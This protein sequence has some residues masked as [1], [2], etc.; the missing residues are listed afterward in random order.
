[1]INHTNIPFHD[2]RLKRI[3]ALLEDL[4]PHQHTDGMNECAICDQELDEAILIEL[5][6]LIADR[7]KTQ[8][9]A[10]EAFMQRMACMEDIPEGHPD[11]GNIAIAFVAKPRTFTIRI[12]AVDDEIVEGSGP[13]LVDAMQ[14]IKESADRASNPS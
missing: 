2:E 10:V 1:V 14:A 11:K 5:E 3:K 4:H 9:G 13:T 6:K 8:V 12:A 7:T